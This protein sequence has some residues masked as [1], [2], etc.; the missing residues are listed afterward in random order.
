MC[1]M[2]VDL[3]CVFM[4]VQ[5]FVRVC[6]YVCIYVCVYVCMYVCMYC[7][8]VCMYVLCEYTGSSKKMNGIWNR[9]NLKRTG[10]I[11]KFDALKFSEKCELLDLP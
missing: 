3:A 10:R 2:Y 7:V 1:F 4:Y 9:Y 6:M 5:V 11:Y 8:H